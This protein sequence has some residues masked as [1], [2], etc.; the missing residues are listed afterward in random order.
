M[1]LLKEKLGSYPNENDYINFKTPEEL[2]VV[3]TLQEYRKLITGNAIGEYKYKERNNEY[4]D[5]LRK[6]NELEEENKKLKEK[7]LELLDSAAHTQ[8]QTESEK[9]VE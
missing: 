1:D 5:L 7:V 3:I 6:K 4:Y 2:T 8:W 9:E